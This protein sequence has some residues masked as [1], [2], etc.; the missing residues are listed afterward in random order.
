MVTSSCATLGTGSRKLLATGMLNYKRNIKW[1][2]TP[3]RREQREALNGL[4]GSVFWLTGLSGPGK[5]TL[6]NAVEQR[7]HESG[8][9]T[10]LLYG[11]NIRHDLCKDLGFSHEDRTEN[12]RRIGEVANLFVD[13]CLVLLDA[14]FLLCRSNCE[15]VTSII[16]PEDFNEA[17]RHCPL[18]VCEQRDVKCLYMKARAGEFSNFTAISAPY[19][20]PLSPVV[21]VN[22]ADYSFEVCV[23]RL[24]AMNF[25]NHLP[26]SGVGLNLCS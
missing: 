17:Y 16:L 7:L 19:E 10:F 14:L 20:A 26:C 1:R 9:R 13:T 22:T 11:D 4:R 12:I 23:E 6:S 5:S 3:V 25:L 18:E 24:L 15:N 8:Y 21:T 2:D